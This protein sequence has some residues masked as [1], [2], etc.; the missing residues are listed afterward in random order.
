MMVY[1]VLTLSKAGGK[2]EIKT[3]GGMMN[4]ELKYCSV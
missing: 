3:R 2:V 1:P 4:L